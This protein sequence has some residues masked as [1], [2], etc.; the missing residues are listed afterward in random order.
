MVSVNVFLPG[1][2]ALLLA[3]RDNNPEF[4][5]DLLSHGMFHRNVILVELFNVKN[6]SSN[7]QCE[8]Y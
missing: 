1:N 2:S 4:V 3:V 6:I 7:I 8:K 5:E